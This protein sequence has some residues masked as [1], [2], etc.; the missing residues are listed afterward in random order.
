MRDVSTQVNVTDVVGKTVYSYS[1][2]ANSLNKELAKQSQRF[3]PG[4]YSLSLVSENLHQV[5]KF[6]KN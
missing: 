5:I 6:Q 3:I 2:N 4:M 1:G